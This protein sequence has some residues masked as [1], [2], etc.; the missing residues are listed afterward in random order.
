[1]AI[2]DISARLTN[3][4]PYL[5]LAE[6]EKYLIDDRKNTVLEVQQMFVKAKNDDDLSIAL[7]A[8]EKI[9][10]KE[11]VESIR[12]KHPDYLESVNTIKVLFIG[13]MAAISSIS[14]EEAE[15]RFREE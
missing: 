6:D 7:K 5:Q 13:I 4:K 2:V 14:Y 9:L 8:F 11:S 3:A 10:G 12:T 1:M 15:K